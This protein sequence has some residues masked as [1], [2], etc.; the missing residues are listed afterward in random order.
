M[1]IG[2]V[3]YGLCH[4]LTSYGETHTYGTHIYIMALHE[5]AYNLLA[6]YT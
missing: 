2:M 4:K 5:S 3:D 6:A 1:G